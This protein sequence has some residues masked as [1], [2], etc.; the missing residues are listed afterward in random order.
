MCR[1]LDEGW[2]K[3]GCTINGITNRGNIY[4]ISVYG[5]VLLILK[6][7][8]KRGGATKVGNRNNRESVCGG[9]CEYVLAKSVEVLI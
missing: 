3:P 1:L 2:R 4:L 8:R 9:V 5:T 7:E 6:V